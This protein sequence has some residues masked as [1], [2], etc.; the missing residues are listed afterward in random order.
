MKLSQ[1]HVA[2][3]VQGVDV[4]VPFETY[5]LPH[6]PPFAWPALTIGSHT[7]RSVGLSLST[8]H[9]RK[10]GNAT[11]L[12]SQVQLIGKTLI[13]ECDQERDVLDTSSS[14]PAKRN[15]VETPKATQHSSRRMSADNR[16]AI[17]SAPKKRNKPFDLN[18]LRKPFLVYPFID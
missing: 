8:N 4:S 10:A 3:S 13:L 12:A 17:P 15:K 7:D 2:W 6:P 11:A 5:A 14:R 18:N 1:Q 16:T 9:K